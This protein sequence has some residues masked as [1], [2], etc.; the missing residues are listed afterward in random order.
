VLVRRQPEPALMNFGNLAKSS[1]EVLPR[2]ILN[3]SVLDE[4]S[5][6][7]LA[8]AILHPTKF[9]DVTCEIERA[10]GL[11]SKTLT[12]LYLSFELVQSH[13]IDGVLEPSILAAGQAKC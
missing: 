4:A 9:V 6:V 7:V 8:L 5:E 10:G 3:P 1:L 12:S 2:L 13:A 11:K